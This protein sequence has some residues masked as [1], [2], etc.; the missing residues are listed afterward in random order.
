MALITVMGRKPRVSSSAGHGMETNGKETP[1]LPQR[2]GQRMKENEFNEAVQAYLDVELKRCGIDHKDV[3]PGRTDIPLSKRAKASDDFGADLHIDIHANAFNSILDDKAGGIETFVWFGN[4]TSKAIGQVIHKHLMQGTKMKDRG[5]KDGSHLYMIKTPKAKC[6]LPE[7]GFMDNKHDVE[8]LLSDAYRKECAVE[9]A[10]GVCEVFGIPYVPENSPSKPSSEVNSD[11][12]EY[13]EV[14]EDVNLY[15]V[16][17]QL[18]KGERYK[19]YSS[20]KHMESLGGGFHV[21][22]GVLRVYGAISTISYTPVEVTEDV[23]LYKVERQLKKGER[24]KRYSSDKYME[25]LG[26]GFHVPKGVLK[27]V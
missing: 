9:L 15:K 14:T 21:P 25:S 26:G 6:V 4:A 7:L 19:R 27:K 16:E 18:K 20:D 12:F 3:A 11:A 23:N 24:Y 1:P 17:R 5:V 10:K 22:K 8:H 2:N 13:V